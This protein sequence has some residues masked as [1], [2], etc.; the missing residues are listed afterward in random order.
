MISNCHDFKCTMCPRRCVDM[1]LL[2]QHI[3]KCH[4][5]TLVCNICDQK[6]VKLRD[7]NLHMSR[8]HHFECD[9]CP[10]SFV[11]LA[12][13]WAH[14]KQCQP[15]TFKCTFCPLSFPKLK[16]FNKHNRD[17]HLMP[18]KC[19]FCLEKFV[20]KEDI[21]R[22]MSSVHEFECEKCKSWF[23]IPQPGPS[24]TYYNVRKPTSL[25]NAPLLCNKETCFVSC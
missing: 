1:N 9:F 24:M 12:E 11:R 4:P 2:T 7:K 20:I 10:S 16:I 21:I 23:Y 5:T 22:H 13:C 3:V 18:F 6:F 14:K 17:Y 25:G 8:S 19:T 15:K